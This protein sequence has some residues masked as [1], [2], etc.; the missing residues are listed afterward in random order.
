MSPITL[1]CKPTSSNLHHTHFRPKT[2]FGVRLQ[3]CT[4]A[5]CADGG[6]RGVLD[7]RGVVVRVA[8]IPRNVGVK[9]GKDV[10]E[11]CGKG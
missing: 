8:E 9:C 7:G 3:P 4:G 2:T 1:R 10:V 5:R 6:D 11:V